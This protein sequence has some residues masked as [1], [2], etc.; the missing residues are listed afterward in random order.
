[1]NPSADN[2]AG[3]HDVSWKR[4]VKGRLNGATD[5]DDRCTAGKSHDAERRR[6]CVGHHRSGSA[7]R[8][9]QAGGVQSTAPVLRRKRGPNPLRLLRLSPAALS[10]WCFSR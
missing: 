5:L 4:M 1:M 2:A 10:F 9:M 3:T 6:A 8:Y 7:K